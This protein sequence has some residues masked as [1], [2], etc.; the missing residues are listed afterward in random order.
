MRIAKVGVIGAGAMGSGIAAHAASAGMSVVLLDVPGDPDRDGV[1]RG[2]VQRA[3]T[4]R[5]APFMDPARAAA[6][7]VGN[8]EDD[9]DLLAGCDWIVEAIIEQLEPKHAL[10]ARLEAICKPTAI[11]SSNTSGIP[12]RMLTDGR[13]LRFRQ[14]FLGTHFFNPPRY[15]HL[16]ELIPTG[17][18]LPEIVSAMRT[19][20]ERMLGKGVVLAKDVPGFIANRL[21]LF[22]MVTTLRLMEQFDLTIDEVDALT[23]PLIGRPKSA[24]FRTGDIS[25]LDVLAHVASGMSQTTGED[26]SLPSWVHTLI[27]EGHLG[28]KTGAGFYQRVG[29]EIQTYDWKRGVYAP[30]QPVDFPELAAFRD[31]PLRDRLK[32]LTTATGRGAEFV[33]RLLV[34]AAWYTLEHTPL[35][36][37]DLI[38]VDRALEWGYGWDAGPFRQFDA[39][40]VDFLRAA[41][42][43]DGKSEPPLLRAAHQDFYREL[44]S[45]LRQLTLAGEYIPVEEIPG[46]I[47]L[48][49]VRLRTGEMDANDDAA[50][51]DLGDGV[52]LLEFR[53]KMNTLGDGVFRTLEG[54]A[55]RIQSG[56]FEGLVIGNGDPRTFSAGAN[57]AGVLRRAQAGEWAALDAGVRAFQA[58]VTSLA[59]FPFPTVVAPFGL[60]LGG[61]AEFA[62]YAPMV[63]THAELY[64]G[65]VEVGVGLLPAGGGTAALLMRFTKDLAPY[66]EADLFEGVKRAFQLISMATTSTSALDARRL[67]VLR[68]ADRI[69]MNRD[70]LLTDAKARVLDLADGY[71]APQPRI[72]RVL[73]REALGNLDYAVWAMQE[74]RYISAH[75]ALIGRKVAYVLSGG[76]GPPR[77]AT[78]Q[79]LLDLEREGF[80]SLLGTP[81]TQ[82]R[83][84]HTL[85][86]GKPL[87]N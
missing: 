33:R 84:A 49:V 77:D 67:G 78:L 73:G 43:A 55:R 76:D 22:G 26:F 1:A 47:D 68:E 36:A 79:D 86:T 48:A 5:P 71:A 75:D 83:I 51:L 87:R 61:G 27:A 70:R 59:S 54:A 42:A 19:F 9:L 23:G 85:T 32:S 3:L 14:H 13:S 44:N 4:A 34:E 40:G 35:L 72:T 66:A 16:L 24:T 11:V 53:A 45:G 74:A 52:L 46:H 50:L 15:M 29:K 30:M 41:F 10:F 57:L 8:I 7:Q 20:S 6:V 62:L 56:G 28:E 37:H 60:T 25:G 12:I 31:Q 80:L 65:L 21:G 38:S 64:M 2:A 39:I 63:Q 82:E 69:S 58:G 17:D 81:A 18:T